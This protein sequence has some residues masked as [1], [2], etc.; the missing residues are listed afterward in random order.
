[1]VT[2]INLNRA[3]K[4]RAKVAKEKSAAENRVKYGQ[5]K[6][7]KAAARQTSKKTEKDLDGK[8]RSED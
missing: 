3:R 6:V 5:S 4:A 2:P 1:M 8:K 7:E